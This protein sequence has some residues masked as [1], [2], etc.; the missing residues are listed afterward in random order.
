VPRPR[1]ALAARIAGAVL[2]LGG[3]AHTAGLLWFYATRGM[4]EGHRVALHLFV[5]YAQW[6]A[7]AL[8]VVASVG[9]R[10]GEAWAR[11]P[12]T[13]GAFLAVAFGATALPLLGGGPA[14]LRV[15]PAVYLAV[16][17]VLGVAGWVGPRRPA[18]P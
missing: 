13:V 8:D 3:T 5:A 12:L 10:R 11:A 9:L 4:P 6:V 1:L 18:A 2:L 17:L 16:H 15:A 7:G 14:I